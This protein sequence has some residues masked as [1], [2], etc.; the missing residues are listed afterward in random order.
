M[1]VLTLAAMLAAT[2]FISES[3]M[4]ANHYIRSGATGANN[5]SDWSNAYTALPTTLVRGDNY[6]IAGGSYAGMTFDTPVSG[7]SVITIKGA[8][9]ADHGIATGWSDT[10]S[11]ENVQAVWT[12][13]VTFSTSYWVFDGSVGPTWS[14]TPSQYGY[15]FNPM[16]NPI[17][18]YNLNTPISNVVIS[19]IAAT[20]PTGDI[21]KIFVSTDNL[22]K[23]VN[24]VTI[25]HNYLYGWGNG[26]W[27][28]SWNLTMD[29]WIFEYNMCLNGYS[30]TTYHGEWVNNNGGYHTNQTTR[31]NWFEGAQNG[32]GVI[33]ANNNDN[34]DAKIY[35]NVFKDIAEGNGII[36]GTSAG[37]LVSPQVYN[38]TFLNKSSGSGGWIGSNVTGTP[39]V[40]NNLIYNMDASMSVSGDYNAYFQTTN[41][42]SE[43]HGQIGSGNPF[44]NVV[45][46]DLRLLAATSAGTILS[47]P[48]NMD[49]NGNVRGADG[50]WDRG[51][52]E[53]VS[54][55]LALS[56]PQNLRIL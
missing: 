14:R 5:G 30:S 20:A 19:H 21:A 11:V 33:V 54:N 53:F 24:N 42:P 43:V 37:N 9:V 39:L 40:Y 47:S 45:G 31:Y 29:L 16:T 6:Y 52:F 12:S 1:Q 25:S 8:T 23:S 50:I 28:T 49:I 7:S 26:Y 55:A 35:G 27:A 46:N 32:T 38:N 44:V 36:T 51:A 17:Y 41:T 56:A 22:T 15:L 3:A 13:S 2:L 34:V 10:Y 4:A 18:V 48:Y